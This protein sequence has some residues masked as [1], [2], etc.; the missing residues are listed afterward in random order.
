MTKNEGNDQRYGMQAA[1]FFNVDFSIQM[2]IYPHFF[3]NLSFSYL[4][5]I[6][7][8]GIVLCLS[9]LLENKIGAETESVNSVEG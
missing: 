6:F 7:E 4:T 5:V 8:F 1:R 3:L 9:D 2:H